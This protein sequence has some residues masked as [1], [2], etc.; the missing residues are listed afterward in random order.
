M[1][2]ALAAALLLA[3]VACPAWAQQCHWPPQRLH[4]SNACGYHKGPPYPHCR[5]SGGDP[6][7]CST[8]ATSPTTSQTNIDAA[9]QACNDHTHRLSP[10]ISFMPGFERCDAGLSLMIKDRPF[11]PPYGP[12]VTRKSDIERDI[13]TVQRGLD[14]PNGSAK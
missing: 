11:P 1:T 3:G 14:D 7:F 10:A 9:W 2:R 13:A 8:W 5:D 12:R 4:D 6:D